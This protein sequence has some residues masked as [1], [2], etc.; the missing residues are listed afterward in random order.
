MA[1]SSGMLSS[2]RALSSYQQLTKL[3]GNTMSELQI[4]YLESLEE[5]VSDMEETLDSLS[6]ANTS[7]ETI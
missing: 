7:P 5:R 2:E 4:H 1:G 3:F 6:E